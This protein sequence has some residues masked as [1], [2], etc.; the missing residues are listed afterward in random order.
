MN[1]NITDDKKQHQWIIH[2]AKEPEIS[3]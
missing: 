2:W 3:K 1:G